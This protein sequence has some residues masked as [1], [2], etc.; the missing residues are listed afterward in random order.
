MDTDTGDVSGP[1]IGRF[2]IGR[3]LLEQLKFIKEGEFHE[4]E[5]APTLKLVGS[6][7]AQS[8]ESRVEV[9]TRISEDD[10]FRMFLSRQ[11]VNNPK[12]Y[13]EACCDQ[14]SAYS[15][16]YFYSIQAQFD[17]TE[18][19]QFFAETTSAKPKTVEKPY[20]ESKSRIAVI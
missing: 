13:I 11:N 17:R 19:I 1:S 3:E 5:G 4:K 15:P 16:I 12:E 10:V 8:E 7:Q 2:V 20:Y 6:L 14:Q 18:L 9:P